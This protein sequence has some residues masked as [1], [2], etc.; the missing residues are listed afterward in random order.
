M[1]VFKFGGS[2]VSSKEAIQ[3][4]LDVRNE[5]NEND[6]PVSVIVVSAV[7]GV[8]DSL[9][10]AVHEAAAGNMHYL[11][12]YKG[13]VDIHDKLLH[14]LFHG[15]A[16][17]YL[18]EDIESLNRQ[19]LEVLEKIYHHNV[20][21][22]K[23]KDE[24]LAFGELYSA[25][26]VSTYLKFNGVKADFLD[27]RTVIRTDNTYGSARVD[28][29]TTYRL[30]KARKA[31]CDAV[32]VA[33]GFIASA[34]DGSTTTLGRGGS[35][36][37][38]T[39]IGVALNATA[40]IKWTDVNGIMSVDPRIVKEAYPIDF[41]S[42]SE[43]YNL[44]KLSSGVLVHHEAIYPLDRKNI[45]FIIKNT[46]NRSFAGTVI[47]KS[48][49]NKM[50]IISL[51]KNCKIVSLRDGMYQWFKEELKR[52]DVKLCLELSGK[53]SHSFVVSDSEYRVLEE[54]YKIR[55][56]REDISII[57]LTSDK[58]DKN[59]EIKAFESLLKSLQIE[60]IDYGWSVGSLSF[61][62]NTK[63]A[64]LVVQRVHECFYN[65]TTLQVHNASAVDVL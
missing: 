34:E 28:L 26:I 58:V 7:R 53:I 22:L 62:V 63:D 39:L 12:I 41:V 44:S 2:S 57:T 46:Y 37:T 17:A 1:H 9:T 15:H 56:I 21:I 33:T 64:E 3:T 6:S 16:P 35:D 47:G 29:A 20:D 52:S 24:V 36:Y 65:Y 42:F 23:S 49:G 11:K 50:P 25:R 5:Y 18:Q 38:A 45:P 43:L 32:T 8:T 40:I 13:L 51:I 30:I 10:R 54:K 4:I 31:N 60:L 14:E 48:C 55:S 59:R 27:A 19:L 61:V